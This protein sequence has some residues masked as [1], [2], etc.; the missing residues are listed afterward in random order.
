MGSI[1]SYQYRADVLDELATHGIR[2]R[3]HTRPAVVRALL[4]DLYTFELRRL[5]AALLRREFPRTEYAGRVTAIRLRYPLLSLPV[6]DWLEPTAAETGRRP[7]SRQGSPC[8]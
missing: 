7:P 4:N 1:P 5:R 2:P 6:T 3:E 8:S